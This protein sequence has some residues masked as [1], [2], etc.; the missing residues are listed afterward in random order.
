MIFVA[1]GVLPREARMRPAITAA[2]REFLVDVAVL[3]SDGKRI[4]GSAPVSLLA[5][6]IEQ[7]VDGPSELGVEADGAFGELPRSLCLTLMLGFEE[8]AAKAELL[9]IGRAEHGFEDAPG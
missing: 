5:L 4:Q 3:A 2:G 1:R 6:Q 9:G 8:K 7:G